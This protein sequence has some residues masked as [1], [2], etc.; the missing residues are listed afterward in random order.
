MQ[1]VLPAEV[2]IQHILPLAPQ[3]GTTCHEYHEHLPSIEKEQKGNIKFPSVKNK[4]PVYIEKGNNI[5]KSAQAGKFTPY[6]G[7]S[8]DDYVMYY[9]NTGNDKVNVKYGQLKDKDK[10]QVKFLL[11]N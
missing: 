7:T 6:L 10:F 2:I 5:V 1:T 4:N 8:P 11:L 9:K 3:L